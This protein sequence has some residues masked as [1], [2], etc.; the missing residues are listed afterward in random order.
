MVYGIWYISCK[1]SLNILLLLWPFCIEKKKRWK[2]T[3]YPQRL[4]WV[5]W[6]PCPCLALTGSCWSLFSNAYQCLQ[7]CWLVCCLH[8][9]RKKVLFPYSLTVLYG[10]LALHDDPSILKNNCRK[11]RNIRDRRFFHEQ[12]GSGKQLK[13]KVSS[14]LT[15]RVFRAFN[16]V[17]CF[18]IL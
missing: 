4:L 5:Q 12:I 13:A 14:F 10:T 8:V 2:C 15:C 1:P 16:N 6:L 18:V 9:T 17:K 11:D 3:H 7:S